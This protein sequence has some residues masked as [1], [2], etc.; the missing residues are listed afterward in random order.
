Q[1]LALA[2]WR[3]LRSQQELN[4]LDYSIETIADYDIGVIGLS[5]QFWYAPDDV[6]ISDLVP[7]AT[8][9]IATLQGLGIDFIIV[10]GCL[11][12]S[13]ASDV[14]G[15]DLLM[16]AGGSVQTIGDTLVVPTIGSYASQVGVLDLTI[17]TSDGTIDSYSFSP[18]HLDSPL[19]P[20]EN[21]VD[22]IDTYN[23]PI[24][25]MLDEVVGFFD[26]QQSVDDLGLLFADAMLEQTGADIGT[27]NYGG[28]RESIDEGFVTYR[29][30]YRVEPFFNFVSTIDILGSEMGAIIG[31]N[32]DSTSISTFESSTWYTI[33]SSNFSVTFFENTYT[34]NNRQDYK[35]ISV[36]EAFADYVS[37]EY[38]VTSSDL[39]SVLDEC[40]S[41][42]NQMPDYYLVGGIPSDIKIQIT[43][44]LLDARNAIVG[45][46]DSLSYTHLLAVLTL[47][48]SHVNVSCPL[49]WLTTNIN[50]II[51]F[52][53]I[54]ATTTTTTSNLPPTD[55]LGPW[56]P[57]IV[58]VILIPIL[59]VV[60]SK[61]LKR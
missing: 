14:S 1:S 48:D 29:D 49:R 28:I 59:L 42:V 12:I 51:S 32:F 11:S 15:I 20:D 60:Y 25:V 27:Y 56:I 13:L 9:T 24:E 23:A 46:D 7:A 31:G 5:P 3:L 37:R 55:I 43:G 58:I 21:I 33:G 39:L 36:V 8:S 54:S 44:E 45:D 34:T 4:P 26:S 61:Y 57:I 22:I 6:T 41:T 53:D 40:S 52:L 2:K 30:I 16:K 10:L 50:G 18:I 19:L 38:P 17:D 35:S 47:V